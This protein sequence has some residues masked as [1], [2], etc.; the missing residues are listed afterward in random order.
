MLQI[1]RLSPN[2]LG[3][4]AALVADFFKGQQNPDGGFRDRDG[5]SDLYYTAF[6]IGGLMALQLPLPVESLAKYLQTFGDGGTL[7]LVHL[8]CLARCWAALPAD[9][10]GR[11]PADRVLQR[12][13]RFRTADGG[14]GAEPG[15]TCG[16]VYGCFLALGAYQDLQYPLPDSAR[17][18]ECIDRLRTHDGGYAN[19]LDMP[20]GL[21]PPSAAAATLLRHLGQRPDVQLR[22]WLWRQWHPEGGFCATR[23]APLPDLL[24]TATALHALESLHADLS[25]IKEP[26]LDFI[27]TLWNARGAFHGNWED[28][29][30]DCEYTYYGLLALGHLSL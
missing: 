30:L 24:S 27:D 12:I 10:D 17:V 23:A 16:T 21:T 6:G 7:D 5:K 18:L 28:D 19:S 11:P 2:V 3:E 20:G 8:A 1:A 22:D 9:L 4:S 13:E 29:E 25:S 15:V 26:C 14:Y